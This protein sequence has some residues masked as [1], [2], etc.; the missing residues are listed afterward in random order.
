MQLITSWLQ[1]EKGFAHTINYITDGTAARGLSRELK[2]LQITCKYLQQSRTRVVRPRR[3]QIVLYSAL[4]ETQKTHTQTQVNHH[5]KAL[6]LSCNCVSLKCAVNVS[7]FPDTWSVYCVLAL[8][9]LTMK[10]TSSSTRGMSRV[11]P[12]ST[13]GGR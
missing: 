4:T 13:D 12:L 11:L 8:G 2:R 9:L 10:Q 6:L 5:N 3:E 1:A 7:L